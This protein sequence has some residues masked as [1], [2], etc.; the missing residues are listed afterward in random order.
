MFM[1]MGLTFVWIRL[2]N[3]Q[4][5]NH[6]THLYDKLLHDEHVAQNCTFIELGED[7]IKY[8]IV[9]YNKVNKKHPSIHSDKNK[10]YYV[11]YC[12]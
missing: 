11:L 10:V 12:I 1:S 6:F 2:T 4:T 3:H 9:A 5:V 8:H 7:F